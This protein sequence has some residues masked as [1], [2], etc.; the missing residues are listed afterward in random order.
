VILVVSPLACS[1]NVIGGEG[2][3][4]D[5]FEDLSLRVRKNL[6]RLGPST[7]GSKDGG[8]PE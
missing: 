2:G 5:S 7:D 6:R 1:G 8:H 4:S 3:V